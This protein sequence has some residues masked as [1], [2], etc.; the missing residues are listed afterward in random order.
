MKLRKVSSD[1]I[2]MTARKFSKKI[3]YVMRSWVSC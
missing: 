1:Y 3:L 2:E